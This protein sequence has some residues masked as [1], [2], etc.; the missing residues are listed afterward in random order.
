MKRDIKYPKK[1]QQ[2]IDIFD[3]TNDGGFNADK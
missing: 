1:Y 2:D 3:P